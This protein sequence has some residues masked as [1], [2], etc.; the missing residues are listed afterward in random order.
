MKGFGVTKKQLVLVLAG[1]FCFGLLGLGGQKVWAQ[2]TSTAVD[3]PAEGGG[4]KPAEGGDKPADK[5]AEG[6]GGG[7]DAPK[8]EES[9][10]GGGGDKPADDKPVVAASEEDQAEALIEKFPW[11]MEKEKDPFKPIVEKKVTVLPSAPPPP[12]KSKKAGDDAPP[13]PPPPPPLKLAVTGIVG[14]DA[15]RL[16]MISFENELRVVKKDEDVKGKFKV[17][18]IL[19]DKIVVYSN[20]EQMRRTFPLGTG[21]GGGGGAKE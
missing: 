14:N 12:M 8:A 6:G 21:P 13:P 15:E 11:K 19:V 20:K 16:A 3:K 1:V 9:P 5:P 18:E 17:V 2:D 7:G 10:A 4:D